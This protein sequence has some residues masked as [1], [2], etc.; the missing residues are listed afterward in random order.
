MSALVNIGSLYARLN[1]YPKALEYYD[2]G[3]VLNEMV[4][5]T[6]GVAIY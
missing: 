2:R 3:I 6:M 5:N 1:N 4:G